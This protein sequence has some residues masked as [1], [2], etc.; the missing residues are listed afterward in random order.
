MSST[1]Q[2]SAVADDR[3]AAGGRR[4]SGVRSTNGKK[5][6]SEKLDITMVT[7][8]ICV[9]GYIWERKSDRL[10]YRNNCED[11]SR[12]LNERFPERY[13]IWCMQ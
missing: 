6:L 1:N 7:N 10:S 8:R 11:L 9:V 5:E 2:G 3:K 4:K 12:Y 13:M